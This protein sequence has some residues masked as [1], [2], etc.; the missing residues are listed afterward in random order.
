MPPHKIKESNP[1][2]NIQG[3]KSFS[4]TQESS[5]ETIFANSNTQLQ[6]SNESN[7]LALASSIEDNMNIDT[8]KRIIELPISEA[9]ASIKR[10]Q[11]ID[12]SRNTHPTLMPTSSKLSALAEVEK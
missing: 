6:N 11:N 12:N 9:S 3:G 10:Q 7:N 5:I 1:S 2:N 4:N 8:T